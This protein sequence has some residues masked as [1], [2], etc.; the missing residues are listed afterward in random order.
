MKKILLS[1]VLLMTSQSWAQMYTPT[2]SE[3]TP[4]QLQ[5]LF[6][7]FKEE[8]M[9]M[10]ERS[11]CFDR[12]YMWSMRADRVHKIKT[13]KVFLFFTRKFRMAKLVTTW[14]GKPFAWWFHV[15]P[16]VRVN[17]ELMVLDATF[18]EKPETVQEWAGSLMRKPE[19]CQELTKLEDYVV[20]RNGESEFQCFY[21]S[22][23]QYVYGP[24]E[25]GLQDL[26]DMSFTPGKVI[27][28]RWT[29]AAANWSVKAYAR[30]YRKAVKKALRF[31]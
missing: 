14:Y 17:G 4:R 5:E 10:K 3:V 28:N 21:T 26:G 20:A 19:P 12:A 15:A 27:M 11:E 23:P 18:S 7:T 2:A 22:T 31:E 30:K 24:L 29:E 13:E 6:A 9:K 16:A 8:D 1:M 25:M